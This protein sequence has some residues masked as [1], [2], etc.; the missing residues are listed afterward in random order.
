MFRNY[1]KVAWRNLMKNKTFS[2]INVFGLTIGLT[3][4][5]LISLYL[6]HELSYD[7]YHKNVNRIYQI[8]TTFVKEGK[9]DRTG[10]TPAPLGRMMQQVFPE[11]ESTTR[12]LK[13]FSDDKTLLQY[14]LPSG[15]KKSFY[16]T[17][18]YLAD[19]NFF[20]VLTYKFREGDPKT[21]LLHPNTL[22]I[23]QEI[24]KKFFGNE[25]AINKIIHI[26]SS[27]N[28][29]HDF[30]ITGVF[31]PSAIPSHIDARLFMSMRGGSVEE[32]MT[33]LNELASNNMF[34]T[35]AVLKPG[36]DPKKLEAKFPAF[37]DKYA[38][39]DLKAM[40]FY[41][42]QFL[43]PLK[44][45]H[46]FSN[47]TLNVTPS[48]SVTYLYILGSIAVFTLLI[49]CINFMNLSTARSSKRS[50]EVGVRKVLGAEKKG[51][52]WQFLGESILMSFIAFCFALALT[53]MLLPLF[54]QVAAKQFSFSVSQIAFL[55]AGF[56]S[57]AVLTGLLAGSYPAFYLSSFAPVKVLKGKISNSLAAVSL[58]KTLVVFQF[59]ISVVLIIASIVISNQMGYLRNTDLG[60]AK[61]QQIVI[62]LRS[63]AS[64]DI[65]PSLK[66][67]IA[68]QSQIQSVGASLYYPG[69]MNPSDMPLYKEGSNMN[70]SKR[71]FTNWIDDGFLQTLG[72]KPIAGRLFSKDHPTDTNYKMVINEQALK[73]LGLPPPEKAVGKFLLADWRGQTY[74]WEI[75]GIVK[76]FHFKD[77]H[78]PVEPYAF[79][80]NNVP[81]YN[82]IVAHAKPQNLPTTLKAIESI[83]KKLNPN[84]PFEF[85]FMDQDF[86]KNYQSDDR[87][88]SIVGYFTI[89]AILISCLGLFGLAAFSA[90]QRIKEIGVRKVLGASIGSIISLLSKDFLKLVGIA[91]L[92]ASPVAWFA[93]NK[94]LQDFAYRT[95]IGWQVFLS[96]AVIAL[97]IALLTVSFQAIK[98]A[99]SNPVK[100]LRTE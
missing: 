84:E 10:V 67:E 35:Y 85:S 13:A 7:T 4:C 79:Q 80:L 100:S 16:E 78:M 96:T 76:D 42:K 61:D 75:I 20:Q 70:D 54:S 25:S 12:L 37:M 98:A 57:L 46:L 18:A 47:T 90:E 86:Y 97:C 56:L 48:G 40:G 36:T 52:I 11:I 28:G 2:F 65:Y 1:L 39:K 19:S 60:F 62:P 24:A 77:L 32:Y 15:E 73:D 38:A 14:N 81:Q 43:T 99:V 91:I 21:A 68:Q 27:T 31:I 93:M 58:R 34:A 66:N 41:K 9:E 63:K 29:D 44:G 69:I 45:V 94:W 50:A 88:E 87:L 55:F 82:Y 23:S 33:Q 6:Y 8:G 83:W 30:S 64:K 59:V 95:N 71:F 92:I 5:M 49:A 51:L 3:S 17:S 26:S 53:R 72:V 74:R 22:V 89:I